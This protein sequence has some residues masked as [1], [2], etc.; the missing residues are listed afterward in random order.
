MTVKRILVVTL[1]LALTVLAGCA[2]Q[3]PASLT[4]SSDQANTGNEQ[5][6]TPAG[7]STINSQHPQETMH[8]TV[9]HATPDAMYLVPEVHVVAKTDH[10]AQTAIELLLAGTQNKQLVAVLPHDTKLRNL[11]VKD[12]IAY[13]DFNNK[14]VKNAHGGSAEEVLI[15]GAIVNTL[16]EF[17]EIHKVQIMVDGK[18]IDTISGHMD[19]SEP[20]S[21][22]ESIIKK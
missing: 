14:L 19:I 6:Q 16:T 15:V 11:S 20:L 1:I 12:H 3:G 7:A 2:N 13:V 17:P 5:E 22:S 9:Y 21:R 4:T 8:L 10:P 18:K